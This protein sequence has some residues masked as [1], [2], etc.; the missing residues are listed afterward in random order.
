MSLSYAIA[1]GKTVEQFLGGFTLDCTKALR[2]LSIRKQGSEFWLHN[3]EIHDQGDEDHLDIHGF[4]YLEMPENRYE[5]YPIKFRTMEDALRY[6]ASEFGA[7]PDQ[8]VNR[9]M[10]QDE[11]GCYLRSGRESA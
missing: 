1:S 9:G 7:R 10:L 6:A 11:Y 5:P 8:W 4:E 2:Y 3:H